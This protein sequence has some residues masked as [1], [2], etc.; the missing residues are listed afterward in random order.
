MIRAATSSSIQRWSFALAASAALGALSV[1]AHAACSVTQLAE[2]KITMDGTRPM[3]D[4]M[5]NGKPE[6]F[7][8]DSSSFYNIV[9][10]PA[11]TEA[12]LQ[13]K[14]PPAM[15]AAK[16]PDGKPLLSLGV[17]TDFVANDLHI[18]NMEFLAGGKQTAG[19]A[20]VIGQPFF[21]AYDVEYDF[22]NRVI[23][24]MR[25]ASCGDAVLAYWSS[26]V[27]KP[28]SVMGIAPTNAAQPFVTAV[29]RLN[30]ADIRVLFD[31]GA[32]ASRISPEVA[33]QAGLNQSTSE[34]VDADPSGGIGRM[35]VKTR[36]G[37]FSSFKV[38][39]EEIKNLRLH[40]GDTR[41]GTDMLLGSDFFL[42]HRIYVSNTQQRVYFTYNGGPV[43]SASR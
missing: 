34:L 9:S 21:H 32:N 12:G 7:V 29:A 41:E 8:I 19:I 18:K 36:L 3:L 27:K 40:V 24:L 10:G 26:T 30:G 33:K 14:P 17:A 20:G 13:L 2:L 31:T 22:A 39:D 4:A 23:R 37:Q 25:P 1:V 6:K 11:A 38:G 28:Y 42:S 43:F 16:G 15:F 5:V 35:T